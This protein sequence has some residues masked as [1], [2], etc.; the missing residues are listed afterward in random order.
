MTIGGGDVLQTAELE[1]LLTARIGKKVSAQILWILRRAEPERF[2]VPQ[3]L[4]VSLLWPREAVD[5]FEVA[6]R[7]RWGL[8]KV[9]APEVPA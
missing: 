1:R 5:A 8:Q 6:V 7:E 4:G 9:T 2:P 3:R